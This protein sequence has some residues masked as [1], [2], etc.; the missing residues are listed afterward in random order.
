[1][2]LRQ[3]LDY[4]LNNWIIIA[5]VSKCNESSTVEFGKFF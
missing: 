4:I 1:M 2:A 3:C 5:L